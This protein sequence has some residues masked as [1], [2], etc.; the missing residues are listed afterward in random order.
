MF[1]SVPFAGN[2]SG[3]V[4]EADDLTQDEMQ[5]IAREMNLS[6]TA[7]VLKSTKEADFEV[8]FFTPEVELDLAGHPTIAAFHALLEESKIF[9]K[10]PIAT[11]TQKTKAG[12]FPVEIYLKQNEVKKIMM[13]LAPPVFSSFD[14]SLSSLAEALRIEAEEIKKTKL[15]LEIIST[16]LSQLMVPVAEIEMVKE[17]EPDFFALRKFCENLKIVSV[18]I[19][20]TETISPFSVAH[21]RN[22]SP[23][24]GVLEN[25]GTGTA[26]GAL[27]AYLVKNEIIRGKSPISLIIEQGHE[28]KRSCE[29]LV[30][31]H[32][33]DEEINT[34]KVGGQAVTIMEGELIF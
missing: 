14:G 13:T 33:S 3:V 16:G 24:V 1:T 2:P 22:F 12:V 32:F 4:T 5:K 20:T 23:V 6:E 34:V 26:N 19:F 9:A 25:L 21:T 29:I 18:H 7:F 10:E 27:G 31:V 8:R 11:V 28:V 15:P 17:I 30:E